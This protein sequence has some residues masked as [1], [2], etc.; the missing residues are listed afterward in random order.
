MKRNIL[1]RITKG[2]LEDESLEIRNQQPALGASAPCK[3]PTKKRAER[4]LAQFTLEEKLRFIS[5]QDKFSVPAIPRLGL[6]QVWMS[7]ATSGVRGHGP[8]TSYPSAVAMAASWNRSLQ[9]ATAKSIGTECR[10]KGI[11]ILLAPGI[12]IARVPT[13]GRNFEYMGEDP[14][15]AGEMAT[16]YIRGV[17]SQGVAASVKHYV[18]NNSDYD[19]HRESSNIDETTLRELYMPAFRKTVIMADTKAVMT[20]YNPV[21][22][23]WMSENRRL[24][25][26][27]LKGEWGFEGVVISDWISVYSTADAVNA[28]LDIEMPQ[29]KWFTT[30]KLKKELY[31]GRIAIEEIDDKV[32]RL[33]TLGFEIGAYDRQVV[34][35]QKAGHSV[36]LDSLLKKNSRTAQTAAE[37][38][39]VLLKNEALLPLNRD[40]IKSLVVTGRTAADTDTGGGGSSYVKAAEPVSILEGLRAAA[41]PDC[42]IEYIEAGKPPYSTSDQNKIEKAD[43]VIFATGF[44]HVLESEFYDRSWQLPGRESEL[45]MAVKELNSNLAVIL[46]AGGDVCTHPWADEVKAI[47]H[48]FYLGQ[49]TGRVISD[50]LFGRIN[51]SG[52]LPFS[53]SRRWEDISAVEHYHQRPE[54]ISFLRFF[55]PQGIRGIRAKKQVDYHEGLAVGYRNF[56]MHHIEPQFP[57]GHGLSYTRFTYETLQLSE[58]HLVARQLPH[59]PDGAV[60]S[61]EVGLTN[62][63]SRAGSEVIQIYVSYPEPPSDYPDRPRPPKALRGFEKI[64]LQPG[65]SKKVRVPID[66]RSFFLFNEN[67]GAWHLISGSYTIMCG[68]SSRDIRL[69]ETLMLSLEAR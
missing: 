51:P 18:A 5:G 65:E 59:T 69:T 61:V 56:D 20:A 19:R 50:I 42:S 36:S 57:F 4:L 14:Y 33:L 34:E 49:N 16:A 48:S 7:D 38:A 53:M 6:P 11:S 60:L 66:N 8:A 39:V 2:I 31:R 55:G 28:G 63:G 24:I 32:R 21:N 15:L 30:K 58:P 46:T 67:D 12:N 37:E 13:C 9:H 45:I 17:Q 23:T 47:L 10:A 52:R 22:G 68:S 1:H 40:K 25:S 35:R 44:D 64:H 62:T 43:A 3:L 54:K 26:D 29:A 27:I 41:G